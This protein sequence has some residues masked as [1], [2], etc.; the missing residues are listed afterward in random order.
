MATTVRSVID[1]LCLTTAPL[2][3]AP[4]TASDVWEPSLRGGQL[5]LVSGT[6][7]LRA[8]TSGAVTQLCKDHFCVLCI[9]RGNGNRARYGLCATGGEEVRDQRPIPATIGAAFHAARLSP[10]R[11]G[12]SDAAGAAGRSA[13]GLRVWYAPATVAHARAAAPDSSAGP[14]R[15]QVA[16]QEPSAG[17]A[18]PRGD[19]AQAGRRGGVARV[20]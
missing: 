18:R 16:K 15:P 2:R 5:H 12:A 17:G 19:R 13:R 6:T 10:P 1:D 8:A 7:K 9:G 4:C 11:A 20:S 14:P 3:F